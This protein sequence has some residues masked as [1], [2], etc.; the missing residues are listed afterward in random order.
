MLS[1]GKVSLSRPPHLSLPDQFFISLNSPIKFGTSGWRGLIA[2]DF[3]FDNLRLAAQGLALTLKTELK[4]KNSDIYNKRPLVIVGYDT[5]FLGKE[6]AIATAEILEKSGLE[7][8][9]TNRSTPTPV[10]A[11]SIRQKK[12]IGG[13]NITASHNPFTYSGFKFSMSNGAG[14][15]LEFTRKIEANTKKLIAKKWQP[16]TSVIGTYNCKNFNPMPAYLNRIRKLID[17]KSISNAKLRIAI[18]FMHGTGHGYLDKILEEAGVKITCFHKKINP[19]F[20]GGSPEPNEVGMAKA[21][22]FVRQGKADLALGLDGD[23]DRFG[24]VDKN[25]N[26]LTPNQVLTLTLYHLKKNRRL[27]GAVVRTVPT[28]HQV[29]AVANLLNVP[30]HET[31]VGFKHIGALMESE[32]IIVGGEESGGLSIGN[33]IP[34]KDG[35]LAC[36]LM[37]E[38]VATEGKSL[39]KILKF[40]EKQTGPFYTDRINIDVPNEKKSAI[41]K[42]LQ[43]GFKNIGSFPVQ[44]FIRTDGY[45][46]LL[47]N[48]EWICF[49]ASGTE[50]VIRC[51]LEAKSMPNLRHLKSASQKLLIIK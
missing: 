5:R 35:V 14:A 50:P 13:V 51:Y 17:M 16:R 1:I 2:Q 31:P 10:I 19:L 32:P 12:A 34:E 48:D 9:L 39:G 21:A 40:I 42:K 38:L 18:E 27:N 3:T 49:R 25:G 4:R 45:K 28:S 30:V 47:P 6:F 46:F 20:G 36:L 41:L 33:H 29:D 11:F 23:A 22:N 15:P 24:V 7:P 43:D 26:W 8:L 37:A 44:K